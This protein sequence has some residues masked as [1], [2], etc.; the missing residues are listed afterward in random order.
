MKRKILTLQSEIFAWKNKAL[1]DD[2]WKDITWKNKSLKDDTWKN[3]TTTLTNYKLTALLF[4]VFCLLSISCTNDCGPPVAWVSYVIDGD[5]LELEN[6]E[7]VRILGINA[8][9][10]GRP[11]ECGA[12]E[13]LA[14]LEDLSLRKTVHL[15]YEADCRDRYGR[16]LAHVYAD[17]QPLGLALIQAGL[18]RPLF[19]GDNRDFEAEYK[20]ATQIAKAKGLGIW[21]KLCD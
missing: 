2:T 9:E 1:K 6:G 8:P 20:L 5:T 21:G 14:L 16:L 15:T 18:A 4:I 19:M 3:N 11:Y 7:R 17:D 10:L 13:A 12:Q